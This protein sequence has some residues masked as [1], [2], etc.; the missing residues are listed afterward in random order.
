MI[1]SPEDAR[2]PR[3]DGARLGWR[4]H[5]NEPEQPARINEL[6]I[7]VLPGARVAQRQAV[8]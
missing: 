2:P 4:A 1:L 8:S 3:V 6:E 7:P 5:P